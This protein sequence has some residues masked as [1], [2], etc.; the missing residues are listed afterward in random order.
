MPPA[1]VAIVDGHKKEEFFAPLRAVWDADWVDCIPAMLLAG[2]TQ[3]AELVLVNDESW[4][5]VA[6]ALPELERRGIPSLHLPDGIVEWRNQWERADRA[7]LF[8]PVLS[9]RIACLGPAQARLLARWGNASRCIVTGS[10]RFD[11][12]LGTPRRT[13]P[14]HGKFRLLVATARTPAFSDRDRVALLDLLRVVREWAEPQP[15][16]AI[17]W[18][19][20]GAL[21]KELGVR[22]VSEPL[23]HQLANCDA[24]WT[25]PSTLQL[26]AM[27]AGLPVALL[28]PFARP[29]YV[30]AAW[31]V[32]T[33]KDCGE[34][35]ES[36]RRREPSRWAY[37]EETLADQ[38]DLQGPAAPKVARAGQALIEAARAHSSFFETPEPENQPSP[39]AVNIELER[40]VAENLALRRVANRGVGQTLYRLFTGLEQR[41]SRKG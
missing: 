41:F 4:A 22:E 34:V 36:M 26:E 32:R 11:E 20:T 2:Q 21:A 37:Q 8:R 33:A 23:R 30:P 14:D 40:L 29:L 35:L 15:Q 6:A 38:V 27:L 17:A 19:L 18:R 25:S 16:L 39:V 28:D 9:T 12:Y 13:P 1:R 5:D 31:Y 24:V 3:G 7:P 10:P